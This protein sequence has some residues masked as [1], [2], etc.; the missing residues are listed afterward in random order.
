MDEAR[1]NPARLVDDTEARRLD[2]ELRYRTLVEHLPVVTYVETSLDPVSGPQY[3]SPQ[4]EPLLGY[5]AAEWLSTPG[6]YEQ[7]IHADDR[8]CV[9]EAKRRA[10]DSGDPL[11][12]EYRMVTEDG[13][14][15]W[16][17]DRSVHVRPDHDPAFRQGFTLDISERRHAEEATR[18]AETR[19]RTLVE[20][21]PLAVY[22]D[23]VDDESSNVYTSPQIELML[24]YPAAQWVSDPSLFVKTL[25]PDDRESVLAAH[26]ATYANGEPHCLDYRLIARDGRIVWVHDEA[27]MIS[28]PAGDETVL[29]GYLLDVTARREAEE[30]LRHQALH[31]PLTGLANR[32]LFTNRVEHAVVRGQATERAAVL[33]LDLD[34]FKGINDTFG[35]PTGD[36]LL[37][38]VA[39]RLQADL[40]PGHTVARIGGDEFAVLLEDESAGAAVGIAERL[41]ADLQE[42]FELG[43]RE[44]LVTASAGVAVGDDADALL[45]SADTAMYRAKASG[46]A[47]L[48]VYTP[49]MED[50]LVGRLELVADLRRASVAE[51]LTLHYQP[52]VDLGTGTIVGVEALVRW[53]HPRLGLLPPAAFIPLAEETGRIV[54]IGRWVLDEA[55]REAAR[56]RIELPGARDLKVGVNVSARQIA[57]PTLI[58]DVCGAL[59][60]SGLEPGALVLEITESVLPRRREEVTSILEEVT[61]LGVRLALDDFGTGYSSLSLLRDLP[62]HT[63]KIDR[64]FIQSIE[65]G[66]Q[67]VA[68]VRAIVELAEAL[69]L[70]VVAE[71]VESAAHVAAVRA[72]GCSLGQGFYF[73]QPLELP[74]LVAA[75]QSDLSPR[76]LGTGREAA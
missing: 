11:C 8:E 6:L 20:Q 73:A 29:Q 26:A 62:V 60:R 4:I 16:V 27:R 18:Q 61:A 37:Q 41:L 68:F 40:A 72:L 54:D 12:I 49:G 69:G 39:T 23:R 59:E 50:N 65:T 64:S 32:A 34:D 1:E 51:E 55:C 46:H 35:Q 24:G 15:V 47:Q 66:P 7:A 75:I 67:R 31:D 74:E 52:I 36:A 71:G 53:Q 76:L 9:I 30:L 48:I 13:R 43:G 44:V 56:C 25:H 3:V 42:P 57:R 19:Y 10:Y 28:D 58:A 17:E 70:E 22:I 33:F 21:L 2:A 63:L 38:A 14:V 5:T 45:R